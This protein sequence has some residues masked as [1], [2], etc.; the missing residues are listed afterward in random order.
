MRDRELVAGVA[1][2][3][4]RSFRELFVTYAP[5]VQ[6]LARRILRDPVLAEDATQDVFVQVWRQASGYRP[7]LG[8][9]RS[10]IMTVAHRRAVDN[11]RREETRRRN[12]TRDL[13]DRSS[14]DDDPGAAVVNAEWARRERRDVRAAL[15]ELSAEQRQVIDLMYFEG[16]SQSEVAVRL[17]IPIGTV[18]SRTRSGMSRLRTSLGAS[19]ATSDLE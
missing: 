18:K 3:H 10:W 5:T 15:H 19:R 14:E 11:V 1:A 6:A 17:Q 2:M 7:E 12:S 13:L 8:S 9:V 4:E 16:L